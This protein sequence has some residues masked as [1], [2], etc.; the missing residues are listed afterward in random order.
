M[1]ADNTIISTLYTT[2]GYRGYTNMFTMSNTF[3]VKVSNE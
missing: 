3:S 2:I 1:I